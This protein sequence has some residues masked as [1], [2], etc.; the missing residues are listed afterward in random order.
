MK[1]MEIVYLSPKELIPYEN[2]PRINDG[3]V[4]PVIESIKA[5]GFKVPLVV[6]K[7]N[8]VVCGHT[9]L[10]AALKMGLERVPCIIADDLS[11]EQIRAFRLADNKVSDFSI[12]DNKL[13][14]TELDEIADDLFTGFDLGGLFDDVLDENDNTPVEENTDGVTYEIVARSQSREK[15]EELQRVWEDLQNA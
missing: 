5:Y 4:Q 8:I 6:D 3:G 12:W 13:L 10:K 7:N 1:D 9:R 15:I 11:D 14:L 2:N